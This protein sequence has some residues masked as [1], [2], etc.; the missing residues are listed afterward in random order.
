M[1]RTL[2]RR[3]L[4]L[5]YGGASVGTMGAVADAVLEAGG[6][7][8]GVIPARLKEREI[9]HAGLTEL[10]VVDSMHERKA[11]MERL[12]DGFIA[13]P[14][15]LGTFE[16]LFEV[17]TWAQLGIHQKP[18]GILNVAGYYEPLRALLQHGIQEGFVPPSQADIV[19]IEADPDRLVEQMLSWTPPVHGPKWIDRSQT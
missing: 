3:G 14:G 1:G 19:L 10:H 18:I 15:G 4:S 6:T 12:S 8:V 11:L 5:V 2:V 9:A 17:V 16:E 13:L 7:A